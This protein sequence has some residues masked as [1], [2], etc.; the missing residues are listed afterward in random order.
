LDLLDASAADSA[1]LLIS[2]K[3]PERDG[4]SILV[5]VFC[6]LGVAIVL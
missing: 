3:R 5:R 4:A 6:G 1:F 2:G